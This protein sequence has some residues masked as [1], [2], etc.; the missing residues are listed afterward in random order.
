MELSRR[1]ALAALASAGIVVGGGVGAL[2]RDRGG[3]S[4]DGEPDAE[5]VL[6]TLTAVAGVVYPSAVGN[7][8]EFVE[9]YAG[10]RLR[11][12]PDYREGATRAVANLDGYVVVH[13]DAEAFVD[14]DGDL[15]EAVLR[16]MGADTADPDP[17]GTITER[18]RYY[19]VN[20]LLFALYASP[21]G[22]DLVGTENP[23]GYPGGRTHGRSPE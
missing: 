12:R 11:R 2:S 1:D 13:T 18:V 19:L 23:I 9:A 15:R 20:E 21:T 22:G 3:A 6:S 10:E 17:D 14:M 16:R 7:V 5:R 8:A 4:A